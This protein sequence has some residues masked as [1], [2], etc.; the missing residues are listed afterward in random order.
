MLIACTLPLCSIVKCQFGEPIFFEGE[1]KEDKI[2]DLYIQ[3]ITCTFK[4]KKDKIPTIQIKNDWR[5]LGN[6]YL[7]TS[8]SVDGDSPICL[9]L[10]SIDLKLFLE[11]YDVFD[12]KYECGWKFRSKDGLFT[13]YIDKWIARKNEATI[14]G[15]KG[16][17]AMSKMMLNSLYGKFATSLEVQSKIPIFRRR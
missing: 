17:R 10:T 12:L 9:I 5:Y 14:I 8:E 3:M 16:I 2:Y 13:E 4:L 15:N 6:E 1:Y 11:Q 7:E